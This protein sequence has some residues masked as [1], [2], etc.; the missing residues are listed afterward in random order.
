MIFSMPSRKPKYSGRTQAVWAERISTLISKSPTALQPAADELKSAAEEVGDFRRLTDQRP[1]HIFLEAPTVTDDELLPEN[2]D[3]N[4]EVKQLVAR[5][6][7]AL[8]SWSSAVSTWAR[9]SEWKALQASARGVRSSTTLLARM[10]SRAKHM[11]DSPPPCAR[12]AALRTHP[13][14]K[15]RVRLL[16]RT[17]GLRETVGHY[18]SSNEPSTHAQS[19]RWCL[20]RETSGTDLPPRETTEHFLLDC[21][22][23]LEARTK[24][25]RDLEEQCSCE[26]EETSCSS[27][28]D[29]LNAEGKCCFILG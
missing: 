14:D 18:E 2:D 25:R 5:L 12:G 8:R 24:F 10:F 4:A 19:C 7:S 29:A 28:Y 20:V 11:H 13:V 17:S 9:E 1:W 27:F 22:L 21:P 16:C 3:Y 15:I 26:A 6:K 23:N